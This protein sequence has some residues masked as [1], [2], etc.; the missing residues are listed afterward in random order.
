MRVL[1][2]E[3]ERFLERVTLRM[4][5]GIARRHSTVLQLLGS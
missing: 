5:S 2:S 4:P 1:G 3:Y